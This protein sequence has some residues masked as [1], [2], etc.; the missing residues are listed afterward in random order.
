MDGTLKRIAIL[1]ATSHIAKGLID[2]FSRGEGAE[3][4]LFSRSPVIVEKFLKMTEV[5]VP[6]SLMAFDDFNSSIYD[7]VINCVGIGEPQKLKEHAATIFQLTEHFDNLILSYLADHRDVL[8]INFSS[9]AAYGSDLSRPVEAETCSIWNINKLT[10]ADNYGIAKF[11]SEAKHRALKDYNIV[12]LRIF[13]YFSRYIN[14]ESKFI[15]AEIISCIR[16]QREFITGPDD[17]VRDYLH[18]EDLAAL[19]VRC[20]NQHTLN[21]VFD[22]YTRKPVTKFELLEYFK[23]AYNLRY[24]IDSDFRPTTTTGAKNIYCSNN[25]K[26]GSLGYAPTFTS[27]EGIIKE[28]E[29]IL[30]SR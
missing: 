13:G 11:C 17:I 3:L 16:D 28:S 20:M 18:P 9:G 5:Y 22:A 25:R 2:N 30:A 19:V 23:T 7:V 10:D 27:L 8:Y 15:L 21:D 4:V 26:A 6:F 14:L 12:D 1:G 24:R 29:Y